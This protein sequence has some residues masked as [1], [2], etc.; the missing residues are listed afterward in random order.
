MPTPYVQKLAKEKGLNVKAV[1]AKWDAAKATIKSQY[2]N[3]KPSEDNYKFY[4]LTMTVF[5]KMMHVNEDVTAAA[6]TLST[7]GGTTDGVA[8]PNSYIYKAKM[9]PDF[10]RKKKKAKNLKEYIEYNLEEGFTE[11]ARETHQKM[12]PNWINSGVFPFEKGDEVITIKNQFDPNT[13]GPKIRKGRVVSLQ[14][15][16]DYVEVAWEDSDVSRIS[17]YKIKK[18]K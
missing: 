6:N 7:V 2:P 17:I 1:E 14:K 13:K 15:S 8:N 16:I 18:I 5:K 9:G 11:R 4:A 12:H 3:V 10:K